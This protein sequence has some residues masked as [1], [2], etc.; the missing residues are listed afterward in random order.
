[1][2]SRAMK[3]HT[4]EHTVRGRPTIKDV[5]FRNGSVNER[6]FTSEHLWVNLSSENHGKQM[7][8]QILILKKSIFRSVIAFLDVIVNQVE[9]QCELWNIWTTRAERLENLLTNVRSTTPKSSNVNCYTMFRKH[10]FK[11]LIMRHF[12]KVANY[13]KFMLS[14]VC[15]PRQNNSSGI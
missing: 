2:I 8:F 5:R 15:W 9:S 14:S 6:S 3:S 7:S 11:P 4:N 12:V 1:M 13:C 10:K